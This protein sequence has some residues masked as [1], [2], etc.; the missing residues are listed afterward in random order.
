[1][2]KKRRLPNIKVCI[3]YVCTEKETNYFFHVGVKFYLLCWRRLNLLFAVTHTHSPI[4]IYI[5][6]H[7]RRAVR[8]SHGHAEKKRESDSVSRV[9]ESEIKRELLRILYTNK[10][11][12]FIYIIY[13][14]SVHTVHSTHCTYIIIHKH[15]EWYS[16][17]IHTNYTVEQKKRSSKEVNLQKKE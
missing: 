8:Q 7:G 5:Y 17:L 13:T 1:M 11:V 2:R 15:T 3:V 10:N 14:Q 9:S 16:P 4:Y 6:V 12:C